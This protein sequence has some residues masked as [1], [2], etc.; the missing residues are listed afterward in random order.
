MVFA[1]SIAIMGVGVNFLSNGLKDM[2]VKAKHYTLINK[3]QQL[4]AAITLLSVDN[5]ESI[6]EFKHLNKDD[7]V[8][9]LVNTGYLKNQD[10]LTYEF[11]DIN[12]DVV[13]KKPIIYFYLSKNSSVT[14]NC[15]INVPQSKLL[16]KENFYELSEG[17]ESCYKIKED[18]Y[19]YIL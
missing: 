12:I 7:K 10:D 8:E 6:K 9:F 5:P 11:K 13:N 15:N 1:I 14:E 17:V 18:N 19:I 16:N 3:S 2:S 4:E